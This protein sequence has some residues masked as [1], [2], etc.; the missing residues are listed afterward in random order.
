MMQQNC[1]EGVSVVDS[2]VNSS[3]LAWRV[4]R[5]AVVFEGQKT[6]TQVLE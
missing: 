6:N 4:L 3:V 5:L 1:V 2:H